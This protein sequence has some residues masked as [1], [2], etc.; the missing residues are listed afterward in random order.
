MKNDQPE[1]ELSG[2]FS[3][4]GQITAQRIYEHYKIV[5]SQ[6][7]L[8]YTLK[9]PGTLYHSLLTVP[10]NNVFN[11]IILQQATDYQKYAQKLFIDYLVS[12]DSGKEDGSPGSGT[13]DDLEQQRLQLVD[14]NKAFHALE[15]EH[16]R[17]IAESQAAIMKNTAEWRSIIQSLAKKIKN[18]II[19]TASDATI[20]NALQTLLV[21]YQISTPCTKQNYTWSKV[22]EILGVGLSSEQRE[23]MMQEMSVLASAIEEMGD[24]IA[25]YNRQV[26]EIGQRLRQFRSELQAFILRANELFS[27]LSDYRPDQLRQSENKE[28][29]H[30]DTDIGA[31]KG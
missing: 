10:F 24:M 20:I 30:F 3:T 1:N 5:L 29:L 23:Q 18:G 25:H 27:L 6:D 12:G 26:K 17:L 28:E 2:W 19:P 14:I 11:G 22:E 8:I 31:E 7:D 9:T 4:Y 16:E 15:I 13:R 21:E